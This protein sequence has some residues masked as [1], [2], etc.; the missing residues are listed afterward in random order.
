M[1]SPRFL[2]PRAPLTSLFLPKPMICALPLQV[3]A[4]TTSHLRRHGL[5]S[6]DRLGSSPPLPTTMVSSSILLDAHVHAISPLFP[7]TVASL[8]LRHLRLPCATVDACP[9]AAASHTTTPSL[10]PL[11][12]IHFRGRRSLSS[13]PSSPM[14]M[15]AQALPLL[16]FHCCLL[17]LTVSLTFYDNRPHLIK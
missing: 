7:S 12:G 13:A 10:L 14:S 17:S 4:S 5:M 8:F 16:C 11:S 15:P 1:S 9:G 3:V 2:P 6:S